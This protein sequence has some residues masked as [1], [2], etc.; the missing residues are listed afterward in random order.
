MTSSPTQTYSKTGRDLSEVE[1][2]VGTDIEP[3]PSTE[4][5]KKGGGTLIDALKRKEDERNF[6]MK[7]FNKNN[8][9]RLLHGR[10]LLYLIFLF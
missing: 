3:S 9:N 2:R 6:I 1:S 8:E 5:G 7:L 4:F 10:L